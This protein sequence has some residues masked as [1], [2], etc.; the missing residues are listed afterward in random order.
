MV[1]FLMGKYFSFSNRNSSDKEIKVTSVLSI[2]HTSILA[3]EG[4]VPR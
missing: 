2:L 3:L 1:D 4:V